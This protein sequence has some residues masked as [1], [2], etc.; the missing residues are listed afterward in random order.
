MRD[1][2]IYPEMLETLH[3]LKGRSPSSSLSINLLARRNHIPY[4]R[5]FKT[6]IVLLITEMKFTAAFVGL[7]AMV[8]LATA[9]PV[10]EPQVKP[11]CGFQTA[12]KP[13][14]LLIT[15]GPRTV[16]LI[17]DQSTV[18]HLHRRLE[19]RGCSRAHPRAHS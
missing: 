14:K 9:A 1:V 6:Q 4:L 5:T 8:T 10:A 16:Q 11:A 13:C 15:A 7:V 12:A 18:V 19:A 17:P 3:A 2:Y